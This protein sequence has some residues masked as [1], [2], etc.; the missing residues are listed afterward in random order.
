MSLRHSRHED[1]ERNNN[2]NLS[3]QVS[4]I[5]SIRRHTLLRT[6]KE[7]A[8]PRHHAVEIAPPRCFL[9]RLVVDRANVA[10]ELL[11]QIRLALCVG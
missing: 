2:A 3:A 10:R 11:L 4:H 5:I 1:R 9:E 7:R 8:N 6:Y